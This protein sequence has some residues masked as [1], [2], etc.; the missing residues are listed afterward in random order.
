VGTK[1]IFDEM[2][3][4]YERREDGGRSMEGS[5]V[6]TP[7]GHL[8]VGGMGS[9]GHGRGE[10]KRLGSSRF[11]SHSNASSGTDGSASGARGNHS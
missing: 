3:G 10:F 5:G 7:G 8:G 1:K 11:R 2:V 9:I 4:E 6:L